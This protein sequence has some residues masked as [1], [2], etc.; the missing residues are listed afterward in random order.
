MPANGAERPSRPRPADTATDAATVLTIAGSSPG[1]PARSRLHDLRRAA[2][3]ARGRDRRAG[4]GPAERE[5]RGRERAAQRLG[6]ALDGSGG[7]RAPPR[8]PALA[9]PPCRPVAVHGT[10]GPSRRAVSRGR[11]PHVARA[12]AITAL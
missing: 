6:D 9:V 7:R 10:P 11:A 3:A 12:A 8:R 5:R 4:D 2:R 1:R